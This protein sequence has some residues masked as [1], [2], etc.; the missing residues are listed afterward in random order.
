MIFQASDYKGRQ[1]LE[2]LDKNN[3]TIAIRINKD[4]LGFLFFIF[5]Y[6]SLTSFISSISFTSFFYFWV[7]G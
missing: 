1:F 7:R 5:F 3:H 2:L 4:R 6:F